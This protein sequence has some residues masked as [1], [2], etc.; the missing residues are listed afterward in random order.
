MG[1]WFTTPTLWIDLFYDVLEYR[2]AQ[3]GNKHVICSNIITAL[4]LQI[5]ILVGKLLFFDQIP[6][7]SY[8]VYIWWAMKWNH[9]LFWWKIK[10]RKFFFYLFI[11]FCVDL[12]SIY[13]CVQYYLFPFVWL[14]SIE[15]WDLARNRTL[16][17]LLLRDVVCLFGW[18]KLFYNFIYNYIWLHLIP[19]VNK[20]LERM[21]DKISR[22]IRW[23]PY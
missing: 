21:H 8:C 14:I 7:F 2:N 13:W 11:V 3:H 15:I 4:L 16:F 6:I 5:N 18:K 12:F 19:T 17:Y 20:G 9:E 1:S 10:L 23:K 22:Y